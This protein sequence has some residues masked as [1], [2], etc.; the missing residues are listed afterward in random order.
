M[1]RVFLT[2]LLC[3]AVSTLAQAET[4]AEYAKLGQKIWP[5]FK[6][7]LAA[8]KMRDEEA[9][10]RFFVLGYESGKTFLDAAFAGEVDEKDIRSTIPVAITLRMQGPSADF[11]LGTI[12]EGVVSD[13]LGEFYDACERC[14]TDDE[15][16]AL[17]ATTEFREMNCALLE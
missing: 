12:W 8:D 3:L 11:I 15:L 7:A 10:A 13:Y 9:Q 2:A 6:C 17:T 4:S 1:K 5:A 16:A 14:L